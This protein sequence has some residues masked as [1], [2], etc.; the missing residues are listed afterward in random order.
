[1]ACQ[2]IPLGN[3]TNAIVCGSHSRSRCACGRR[4]DLLCDWKVP[5]RRSGTC[6]Q[7]VCSS[8]ATSPAPGKDLCPEHARAFLAWSAQR[9]SGRRNGK[10]R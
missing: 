5:S 4:A 1:M 9:S 10:A 2:L 6:D 8:C 7:P 3:G